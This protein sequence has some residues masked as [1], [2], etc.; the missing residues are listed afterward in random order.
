MEKYM[1]WNFIKDEQKKTLVFECH[2][3]LLG[4]DIGDWTVETVSMDRID[5]EYFGAIAVW[6][7]FEQYVDFFRSFL[8]EKCRDVVKIDDVGLLD[9]CDE[10]IDLASKYTPSELLDELMW[11]D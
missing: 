2:T 3:Y 5:L 8:R 9:E 7:I 11:I 4:G 6:D 10:Y 1:E